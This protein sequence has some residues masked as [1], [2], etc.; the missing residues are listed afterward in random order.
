MPSPAGGD[1]HREAAIIS[2]RYHI[3]AVILTVLGMVIL[4]V[5]VYCQFAGNRDL[6]VPVGL[7]MSVVSF[8]SAG[9]WRSTARTYQQSGTHGKGTSR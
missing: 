4:A 9:L 3:G 8:A 6:C 2:R 7:G 5:T 1:P